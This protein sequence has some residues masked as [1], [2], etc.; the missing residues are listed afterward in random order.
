MPKSTFSILSRSWPDAEISAVCRLIT[1]GKAPTYVSQSNVF[2]IGQRCVRESGFDTSSARPHN[3]KRMAN[4]L[5]AEPGDVL[6]NSTGTGTIGRSCVFNAPG[7]YVVDSHVTVLRP[8]RDKL[9]PRWLAAILQSPQGQHFLESRC[10]SGS[11]NQ[12]ELARGPLAKL[13]IPLPPFTEQKGIGD[14]ID[15][16]HATICE[17]ETLIGKLRRMHEGLLHD[18]LTQGMDEHGQ[19]RDP[20]THHTQFQKTMLGRIPAEWEVVR[21]EQVGEVRLGRQRS[22]QHQ[23]GHYTTP[24]LRVANVYDGWIDYS[25]VLS[26]D[27]TPSER[28]SYMLQPGDILLNEGQSLELVGRSAIYDGAQQ[29][30]CFQNTLVRFRCNATSI[31]EYCQAVFKYWLDIGR[32]TTVAKQTT[33]IAHL[34]ADRFAKMHFPRPSISEQQRIAE[35]LRVSSE[36]VR[37]EEAYRDKLKLLKQGLMDDLLTGRVRV[38]VAEEAVV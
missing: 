27:F 12:V 37:A 34:G 21:V 28:E 5:I 1:R 24:Y 17:T 9:D 6:V 22:P 32:F 14:V 23:T 13:R 16:A 8:D 15:A 10:Y 11:T 3:A 20:N 2:A 31:P 7:Q 19:L 29:T 30:Y 18:L 33:S 4:A 25:D 35:T 26:M 38:P 36:R